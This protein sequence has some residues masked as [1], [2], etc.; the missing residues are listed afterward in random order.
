MTINSLLCYFTAEEIAPKLLYVVVVI[1]C[2][3]H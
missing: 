3:C 1:W 2:W